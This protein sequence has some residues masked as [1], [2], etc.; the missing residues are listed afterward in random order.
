MVM[1]SRQLSDE[2]LKD[3]EP[4]KIS[5]FDIP[6]IVKKIK[7]GDW[8]IHED[9]QVPEKSLL[10]WRRRKYEPYEIGVVHVRYPKSQLHPEKK[11]KFPLYFLSV[12][13]G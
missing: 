13:G 7:S 2:V 1:S 8:H 6:E 10:L 11:Y 4:H 5:V 12:R 3:K 9:K